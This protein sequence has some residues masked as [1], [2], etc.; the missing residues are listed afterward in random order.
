MQDLIEALTIFAKYTS[1]DSINCEH[2]EFQVAVN[3]YDVS[4]EDTER[5]DELSF[6]PDE[7]DGF[8]SRRFGSCQVV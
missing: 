6:T 4:P 3:P 5:L 7:Y 2:D 8:T 1:E